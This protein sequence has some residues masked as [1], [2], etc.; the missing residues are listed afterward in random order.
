MYQTITGVCNNLKNPYLG[1]S[2]SL[3]K[4]ISAPEYYDC[5]EVSKGGYVD[6]SMPHPPFSCPGRSQNLPN[7]REVSDIFHPEVELPQSHYSLMVMQ[8]GQFLDHA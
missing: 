3:L 1:A 8:F 6:K 4:R 5:K 7:V 2:N